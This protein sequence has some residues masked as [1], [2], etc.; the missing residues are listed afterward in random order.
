[1]T[2]GKRHVL[3]G[4]YAFAIAVVNLPTLHG[5]F[6]MGRREPTAS[7]LVFVPTVSIALVYL[8]RH[9]IFE[10][11]RFERVVGVGVI[12]AGVV[13]QLIRQ[14]YQIPQGPGDELILTAAGIALLWAGGF[15][16]VYGRAAGLRA[17]FRL[18]FLGFMIP[19]P[20]VVLEA[21]VLFLKTGSTE[22]VSTLF[23]LTGTPY[24]REGFVFALPS[25][26][27]EVA[28][29]CS[30]IRSS[31]ALLLTSLLA[32]HLFLQFGWT[33]AVFAAAVIPL[34]ILKNAVRIV[35]LSLLSIHVDPD[36][37]TGQLHHEGG[38]VF[39]LLALS[40]LA[41]VLAVLQRSELAGAGLSR[42]RKPI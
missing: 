42:L 9:T 1:M 21:A 23:T 13:L 8:G 7:H 6:E 15:L 11:I 5:L 34:A 2:I 16:L 3:F 30:G 35:S 26:V 27:I 36:F 20:G 40:L 37:L 4:A 19:I 10:T 14:L 17:L 39:F 38:I 32:G 31:I 24:Y 22:A 29:E 12:G 25:V 28:D 18:C 33:K 41:P